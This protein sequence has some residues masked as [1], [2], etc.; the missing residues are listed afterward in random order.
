MV[1]MCLKLTLGDG[2]PAG[3][4]VENPGVGVQ[5]QCCGLSAGWL[6]A[7]CSAF[8][9]FNV[10]NGRSGRI[11]YCDVDMHTFIS[12]SPNPQSGCIWMWY[13]EVLY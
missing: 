10:P 1:P 12:W 11:P 13:L 9:A 7:D 4:V 5:P 2:E 6:W 8:V 3:Q